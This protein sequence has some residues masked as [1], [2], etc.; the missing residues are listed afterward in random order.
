MDGKYRYT[1]AYSL[2]DKEPSYC[3]VLHSPD[4]A[5]AV[6]TGLDADKQRV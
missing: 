6:L 1:G 5:V 3:M 4:R 2:N